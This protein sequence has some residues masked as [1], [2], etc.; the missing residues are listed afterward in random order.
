MKNNVYLDL[1]HCLCTATLPN[2]NQFRQMYLH[3]NAQTS[4]QNNFSD[5]E[6]NISFFI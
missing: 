4:K 6:R 5:T 2:E 3:L 1:L